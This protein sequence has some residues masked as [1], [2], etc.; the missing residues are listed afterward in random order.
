MLFDDLKW[1][2]SR[3]S[4]FCSRMRS[5]VYLFYKY[6]SISN[7]YCTFYIFRNQNHKKKKETMLAQYWANTGLLLGE[8]TA[9]LSESWH[10]EKFTS[11]IIHRILGSSSKTSRKSHSY[12]AKNWI[13]TLSRRDHLDIW[14]NK[15]PPVSHLPCHH[16]PT[17]TPSLFS[18]I[19][20][21]LLGRALSSS[22]LLA[23][24]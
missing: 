16:S 7:A 19:I 20:Q 21:T 23:T 12:V 6:D 10:L 1:I 22:C 24:Y 3:S 5:L 15:R 9:V 14:L 2:F 8:V 11:F 18:A 4:L 13:P 17:F